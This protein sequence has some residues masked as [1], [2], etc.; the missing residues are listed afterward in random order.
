MRRS[1][2]AGTT[3]SARTLKGS[4]MNSAQPISRPRPSVLLTS[5]NASTSLRK[6]S[7]CATEKTLDQFFKEKRGS[8]GLRY[9]C[10]ECDK[11]RRRSYHHWKE[12]ATCLDIQN[13]KRL[14]REW[15]QKNRMVAR[16]YYLIRGAKRR[17][18]AKGLPFDLDAH[19]DELQ[20]RI[21]GGMCELSGFPLDLTM[22]RGFASP[23]LDR[24]RP[25]LGYVYANVRVV[26]HLI[27]CALGSWG[28]DALLSVMRSWERK[29]GR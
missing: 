4:D 25:E 24:I 23:S 19:V 17:A 28:E 29:S 11:K 27:N 8:G 5:A 18:D 2:S 26:C 10:K 14:K 7:K 21:D 13:A 6:C 9:S 12:R 22:K 1:I 3:T 15:V 20:R 16:A